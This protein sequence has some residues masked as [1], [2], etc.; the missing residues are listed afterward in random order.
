MRGS[1]VQYRSSK[2]RHRSAKHTHSQPLH[3]RTFAWLA[4]PSRRPE[5][6]TAATS[7]AAAATA[8]IESLARMRRSASHSAP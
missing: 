5:A 7:A 4:K 8:M 2:Q 3:N 1:A 6:N